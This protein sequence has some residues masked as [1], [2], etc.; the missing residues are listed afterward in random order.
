MD[1]TLVGVLHAPD[2]P[3]STG[4]VIVVGGPQ[5]RIGSHR[6]FLLLARDLAAHGVAV[7]RFDC[8][9]MGDSEGDFPGFEHIEP[10]VAAAVDVMM[11][12]LPSLR[13]VVLWGLCDATLAIALEAQRDRRISGVVLLNPWVRSEA[14]LARTQLKHYYT[15]RLFQREFLSKIISGQFNPWTSARALLANVTRALRPRSA[16]SG[17]AAAS[18]ASPLIERLGDALERFEGRILL[19]ISGRDLTAKEFD[20]AA[21]GSR[22]WHK[23]FADP[24]LTRRELAAADHTFS[25]RLWRDQVAGWTREWIDH[26]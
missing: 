19:I 16:S 5:Y 8:R 13:R 9:G 17:A 26:A 6:Q 1:K 14:S 12:Q 4:L 21:Q 10:D 22:E 23:L 3:L 2:S 11:R 25:R 15:A 20:D 18:T 7:L 24:R